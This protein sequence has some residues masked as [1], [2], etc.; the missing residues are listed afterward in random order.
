MLLGAHINTSPTAFKRYRH[1]ET[2]HVLPR[3]T[4]MHVRNASYTAGFAVADGTHST[5]FRT[6]RFGRGALVRVHVR[7]SYEQSV[8]QAG[9]ASQV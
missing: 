6:R 3:E 7:D 1:R 8:H 5:S 9:F 2:R 4:I